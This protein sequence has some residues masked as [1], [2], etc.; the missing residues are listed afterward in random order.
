M[1]ARINHP[2][3]AVDRSLHHDVAAGHPAALVDVGWEFRGPGAKAAE[4]HA[5]LRVVR[6]RRPRGIPYDR[7]AVDLTDRRPAAPRPA[8]PRTRVRPDGVRV[9]AGPLAMLPGVDHGPALRM[10]LHPVPGG[11]VYVA[12]DLVLRELGDDVRGHVHAGM[13]GTAQLHAFWST[14]TVDLPPDRPV[15]VRLRSDRD[16]ELLSL[17]EVL[18]PMEMRVVSYRLDESPVGTQR[19][20]YLLP[21]VDPEIVAR[22]ES[23]RVP[24]E[25]IEATQEEEDA[26]RRSSGVFLSRR[27]TDRF[28]RRTLPTVTHSL[29][30]SDEADV[31]DVYVDGSVLRGSRIGGAAA[32]GGPSMW[33]VQAVNGATTPL[34]VEL[35]ALVLG[36]VV[37]AWAGVPGE[38]VTIHSDSRAALA[39]LNAARRERLTL[40]G[41]RGERVRRTLRRLLAAVDL[42]QAADVRVETTWVKG[43]VG[44]QGNEL[45]DDLARAA[46]RHA[47]VGTSEEDLRRRLDRL[48]D[49]HEEAEAEAGQT[50][51]R[52]EAAEV[53]RPMLPRRS[54]GPRL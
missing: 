49:L 37:S 9:V 4:R 48:I 34:E 13:V 50:P 1:G 10:D 2:R 20:S 35:E 31:A 17:L 8:P 6:A 54:P 5:P 38:R 19:S 42:A 7:P 45:A 27:R 29:S 44:V 26:L 33:A 23:P 21:D 46:A 47:G 28:L 12:R 43:H 39:L 14:V 24:L 22:T 18:A 30:F 53:H 52:A 16:A 15:I 25:A 32:V 36:H 41:A 11:I 51:A 3:T 40:G